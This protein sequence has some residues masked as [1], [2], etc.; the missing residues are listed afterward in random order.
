MKTFKLALLL[1]IVAFPLNFNDELKVSSADG[2]SNYSIN[3][4]ITYQVDINYTFTHTR[5]SPQNYYFKVARLNNRQPNSSITQFTPPYQE[6]QLLYNSI[7]GFDTLIMG[8]QDKFNNTYDLFNATMSTSETITLN[9]KYIVKLNEVAFGDIVDTDIGSY[10]TSDEMFNLYC[11]NTETYYEID[12]PALIAASNSIVDPS[13]NPLEKARKINNW[14][15]SHLEYDEDA[16]LP[17]EEMGAKWAFDNNFGD[18]SEYSSLM[19]TLLRIQGIPAR[20]VSG[21]LIDLKKDFNPAVGQ[22]ITFT[23]DSSG[24]SDFLGHAW[25]EYYIPKI[26][27]IACEPQNSDYYKKID[28]RRLNVNIGAWFFIPGATPPHDYESEFSFIP[29]PVASDHDA[30]TFNA[31]VKITILETDLLFTKVIIIIVIVSI[32]GVVIIGV[33]LLIRSNRKKRKQYE[34]FSSY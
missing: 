22:V 25:V 11:N 4:S 26:G 24:S 31:K 19:I 17:A 18:C 15:I 2:V 6:A 34:Q 3:Q 16:T 27:W 8:S 9:Q 28:Y 14:V 13:D 33:T 30:Y 5:I 32:V 21:Y 7:T 20:K 12:D 23:A 29:S 10:D 1:L